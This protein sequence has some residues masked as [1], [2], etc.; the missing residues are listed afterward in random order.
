[1]L[2][3]V[4]PA[5]LA[6]LLG[7]LA[8]QADGAVAYLA[9]IR[10]AS[11]GAIALGYLGVAIFVFRKLSG[12]RRWA[13][14]LWG[15]LALRVAYVPLLASGVVLTSWLEWGARFFGGENLSLPVHYM[16]PCFWAMAATTWTLLAIAAASRPKDIGWDMVTLIV[17]GLGVLSFWK[18]ADRHP[19]PH[20]FESKAPSPATSGPTYLDVAE[21]SAR[22]VVTRI[23]ATGGVVRNALQG[24][25]GWSAV[26]REELAARFRGAP[27][28]S[29]KDRISCLEAALVRARKDLTP[30]KAN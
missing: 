11:L 7:I 6:G 29:Q 5:I 16:L 13:A 30:K 10:I 23:L 17:I 18:P 22:D 28:L 15:L 1:M 14:L 20:R 19:S 2:V 25:R 21:D 27:A 24:R 26:V 8:H 4:L 3:F 9:Q 12:W